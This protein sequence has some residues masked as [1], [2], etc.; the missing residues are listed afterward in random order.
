MFDV[1]GRCADHG[2]LAVHA[3]KSQNAR[4]Q[5][6]C[7]KGKRKTHA[8]NGRAQKDSAKRTP[9]TDARKRIA[10]NARRQRPCAKGGGKTRATSSRAHSEAQ[11]RTQPKSAHARNGKP[12]PRR[13]P[14]GRDFAG[15]N[16]PTIVSMWAIT[17]NCPQSA[18]WAGPFAGPTGRGPSDINA[19][20]SVAAMDAPLAR[21]L[22]DGGG[23]NLACVPVFGESH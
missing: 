18:Q 14:R 13:G 12:R 21:A 19:R 17:P 7:T 6:P 4:R 10:Q 2:E 15:G 11:K 20:L 1:T 16:Q 22:H 3:R 8:A 5:R 23:R 9:P